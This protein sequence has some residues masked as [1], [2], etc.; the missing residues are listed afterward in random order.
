VVLSGGGAPEERFEAAAASQAGIFRPKVV[1]GYPVKR[2]LVLEFS[3]EGESDR[4]DL[5]EVSV[6][7]SA[8]QHSSA[9]DPPDNDNLVTLLLEQQWNLDFRVAKVERRKMRAGFS[10]YGRVRELEDSATTIKSPVAGRLMSEDGALPAPGARIA[11][12]DVLASVLPMMDASGTDRS[13]LLRARDEARA[14]ARW[15]KGEVARVE[16]L[17]EQG[18]AS[19]RS[20]AQARLAMEEANAQRRAAD[21]QLTQL[22][23]VQTVEG[24]KAAAI[25][26]RAPHDGQVR[27]VHVRSGAYVSPNEALLD[28]VDPDGRIFELDV[29]EIEAGRLDDVLGA[30]VQIDG[31]AEAYELTADDRIDAPLS[32]DAVR[33]TIPLWWRLRDASNSLPAGLALSAQL[34]TGASEEQVA[35][36]RS[37]IVQDAGLSVVF[38]QVDGERF[39]RRPIRAGARDGDHTTVLSGLDERDSVVVEGAYLLKLASLKDAAPTQGHTH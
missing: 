35:I 9:E 10:V 22:A 13:S 1:P 25:T 17:L 20:L 38:V 33:H 2:K 36:P 12:N 29:P 27:R 8:D 4:H 32:V 39:Q 6:M 15:A 16:G 21:R 24:A 11:R 28:L 37:A 14:K 26:L 19:E 18:A 31:R 7:A 30:R 34:W 5:G 3:S 23:A